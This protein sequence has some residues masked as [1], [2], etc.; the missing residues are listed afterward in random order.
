MVLSDGKLE[1]FNDLSTR[2][3]NEVTQMKDFVNGI[4]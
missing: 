4:D 1:F 3:L 2:I